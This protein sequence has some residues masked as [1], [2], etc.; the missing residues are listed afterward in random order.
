MI[1][2]S[3]GDSVRCVQAGDNGVRLPSDDQMGKNKTSPARTAGLVTKD[4]R[5]FF[6]NRKINLK[7]DEP[8][9]MR[10]CLAE[11]RKSLIKAQRDAKELNG[12]SLLIRNGLQQG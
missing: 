1:S 9:Y 10:K 6:F 3:A 2:T 4:G 11:A 12:H 7:G 8:D 5:P